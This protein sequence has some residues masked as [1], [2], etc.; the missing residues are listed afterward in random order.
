VRAVP[1]ADQSWRPEAL[2]TKCSAST[3]T[4]VTRPTAVDLLDDRL[5]DDPVADGRRGQVVELD[6]HADRGLALSE[7][8]C[9]RGQRRLFA[10][11]QQEGC[12]QDRNLSGAQGDRGVG[13]ADDVLDLC[14]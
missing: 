4:R 10:Q 5:G 14:A 6:L 8:R 9:D 7:L 2:A 12:G 1:P 13:F 3:T 11:R